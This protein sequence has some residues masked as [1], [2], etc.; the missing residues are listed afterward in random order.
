MLMVFVEEVSRDFETVENAQ[1]TFFA[2]SSVP[3]QFAESTVYQ[4]SMALARTV[5]STDTSVALPVYTAA[6][7]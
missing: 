7:Q 1:L 4:V 2:K 3:H 6:K 5:Q